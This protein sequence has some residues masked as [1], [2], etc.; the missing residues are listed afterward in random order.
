MEL[1]RFFGIAFILVGISHMVQPRLWVELFAQLAKT[2]VLSLV[3]AFFTLPQGL[4]IVVWHNVW[5]TDLS[6]L[7]TVVGWSMTLK[8][9]IYLLY[10][11]HADRIVGG[12]GSK[13]QGYVLGGAIMLVLGGL[14]ALQGFHLGTS[15]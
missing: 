1:E 8:S 15:V 12:I 7:L 5:R 6:V 13:W 10:P 3:I 9:T 4:A 14:M 11:R 2:G